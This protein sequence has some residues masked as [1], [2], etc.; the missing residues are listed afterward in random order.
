MNNLDDEE[1]IEA[2]SEASRAGVEVRLLVRGMNALV[3][4]SEGSERLEARSLVGRLLEHSRALMFCNAEKPLVFTTSADWMGRNMDG[5]VEVTCPIRDKVLRRQLL[6]YFDLQWRDS[7]NARVW[8]AQD[9]N[10]R[11]EVQGEPFDAQ[12]S[13]REWLAD[14]AY[15]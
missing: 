11:L 13:I 12:A 7:V 4:S 3:P 8:D 6:E 15:R 1:L 5:R 2:L 10:R 9:A 14:A